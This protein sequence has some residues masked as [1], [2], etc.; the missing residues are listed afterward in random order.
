[1]TGTELVVDLRGRRI[2]SLRD[3]WAAVAEPCGLPPWFGR[4]L[5]AWWDT[6]ETGGISEVV[7]RYDLLVFRADATGLFAPG[8]PDGARLMDPESTRTRFELS[9]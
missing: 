4:N 7:D 3:F 2:G 8:N 6:V 9:G 1:M 5:D